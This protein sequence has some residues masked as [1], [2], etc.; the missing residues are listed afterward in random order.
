M[1]C[2]DFDE[3]FICASFNL[4]ISEGLEEKLYISFVCSGATSGVESWFSQITVMKSFVK[5]VTK[6]YWRLITSINKNEIDVKIKM[7][8]CVV[9]KK[10]KKKVFF[11][12]PTVLVKEVV[13]WN[14]V[15]Y[16]RSNFKDDLSYSV[17]CLID[18]CQGE[19][20]LLDLQK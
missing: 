13:K 10:W 19:K 4:F 2:Q 12:T 11:A 1:L 17:K 5:S 7:T 9:M 8:E 14:N 16:M 6:S 3:P 18:F 15:L 20:K